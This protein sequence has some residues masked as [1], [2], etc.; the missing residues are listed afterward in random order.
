MGQTITVTSPGLNQATTI[1]VVAA[2]GITTADYAIAFP[3]TK[4]SNTQLESIEIDGITFDYDPAVH[5]YA[6]SLPYGVTVIPDITF[7]KAEMEQQVELCTNGFSA[8]ATLKVTAEDGTEATY[9]LTFQ[10]AYAPYDNALLSI[11]VENIGALDLTAGTDHVVTLP[12]GTTEI[13]FSIVKQ[14][15]NSF[16]V[17]SFVSEV[18]GNFKKRDVDG[19]EN[20]NLLDTGDTS[21]V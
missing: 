2:D 9:T 8:P 20:E 5:D 21:A 3:V 7:T 4:S 15:P 10:V 18:M 11:V 19:K 12:Y 14:Y 17:M 13:H 1:H 6:I 16:A